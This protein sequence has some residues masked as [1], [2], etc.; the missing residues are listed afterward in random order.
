[1]TPLERQPCARGLTSACFRAHPQWARQA[2]A[3]RLLH[4]ITPKQLTKRLPPSLNKALVVPGLALPPGVSLADLPAGTLI[5]TTAVFPPGWTAG[6][7]LPPGTAAPPTT[8]PDEPGAS[9][10]PPFYVGPGA[11]VYPKANPAP[12][13][14]VAWFSEP[15]DNL[16][17]GSWTDESFLGGS[18]ECIDGVLHLDCMG[19]DGS[20][21]IQRID[22][23][24]YPENFSLVAAITVVSGT[25]QIEME[26]RTDAYRARLVLKPPNMVDVLGRYSVEDVDVGNYLGTEIVWRLACTGHLGTLYMNDVAIIEDYHLF[27][28]SSGA[29][30]I[31]LRCRR[32]GATL[33]DYF[34]LTE[35]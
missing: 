12:S 35:P 5:T 26:R 34:N 23:T 1:M 15:F 14:A 18:A 8:A 2:L 20:G 27:M 9:V 24:N 31:N 11:P 28:S 22:T 21:D 19:P 4:A 32:T 33:W 30:E 13:G 29:G 3:A 6:D 25:Y 16:T 7:P 10:V 17:A